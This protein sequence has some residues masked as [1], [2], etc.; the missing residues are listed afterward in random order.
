MKG[1]LSLFKSNSFISL[2]GN[3]ISALLGLLSF[4]L[5]ARFTT[6]QDLGIWII[7]LTVYG[8]FD[9]LRTGMVLN[10]FIKNFTQS[11]NEEEQNQVVGSAWHLSFLVNLIYVIFTALCYLVFYMFNILPN[12]HFFFIWLILLSIFSLP[13]N[14]ATWLLNAKLSIFKMSLSRIINQ[15][16]FI[17]LI[18]FFLKF[19]D[20]KKIIL[21][22]FAYTLAQLVT[23][24][25]CIIIGWS[26]IKL[27]FHKTKEGLKELFHFG[28]YSMGTLIGS[29]LLRSSDS[30]LI[31]KFIGTIA[32]ATY[33]VP[34]KV[35]DVFDLVIRSFAITNMPVLSKIY[36]S[37]NL[38]LLKK[39]LK[40]KLAFCFYCYFQLLLY[41]LFLQ[42]KL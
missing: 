33:N 25:F 22:L 7:F 23:S 20:E 11:K 1:L 28:K 42:N 14:F 8:I 36:S 40:E 30:F 39:S 4:A 13:F 5:L 34:S 37:G 21:I 41:L 16:V 26:G 12:Y 3:G 35:V 29:N 31:G 19:I 24:I 27:Y 17:L 32:V 15:V 38:V 6:K 2:F 9:T 18:V 10:A